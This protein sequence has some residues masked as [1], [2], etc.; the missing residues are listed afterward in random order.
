MVD[1][2]QNADRINLIV[3]RLDLN[4][5]RCLDLGCR[6]GYLLQQLQ[7]YNWCKILGVEDQRVP[8][9]EEYVESWEEV[10]G[11][12]DLITCIQ[13]PEYI[14]IEKMMTFLN[15]N[16]TILV[17]LPKENINGLV[18]KL[19]ELELSHMVLDQG[20][21]V[22]IFIGDKYK[23]HKVDKVYYS[24]E[25]PDLDS[26]EEYLRWLMKQYGKVVDI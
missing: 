10:E 22:D 3:D 17:E 26:K 20:I 5:K 2:I 11:K 9:I 16:G 1:E 23:E 13:R 21:L 8:D 12:F 15:E 24:F 19:T 14:D 4:P 7:V 25:S 18:D 6:S